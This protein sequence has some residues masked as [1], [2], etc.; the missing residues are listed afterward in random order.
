MI[1][2][3]PGRGWVVRRSAGFT[4]V[5][6]LATLALVAIVL[7]VAMSGI[8]LA[9]RVADESRRQTEAATLARNK[10]AEIVAYNLWQTTT[11]SGDFGPDMPEY[12]WAATVSD[13]QVANVRQIDVA[14]TWVHGGRERSVAVSTLLYMGSSG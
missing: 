8:S 13:W 1:G 3:V 10:L 6:I 2:T 14:V 5:E 9:L 4:L 7:P 12:R 11:L